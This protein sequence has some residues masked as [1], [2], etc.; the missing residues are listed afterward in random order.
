MSVH[1][2][3]NGQWYV[4]F[5]KRTYR[6][7]KT[8]HEADLFECQLK[9]GEAKANGRGM[10]FEEGFRDYM[11]KQKINTTYGTVQKRYNIYERIIKPHFRVSSRIENITRLDCRHF[12]DWLYSTEYATSYKN[13]ILN[14]LNAIFKHCER[15]FDVGNN[16]ASSLEKFKPRYEEI[17]LK[18]KKQFNVWTP[19]EF[20]RF[21]SCVY[22][23]QYRLFLIVLYFTGMRKGEAM[24]L[25]WS[26]YNSGI[27]DIN[28]NITTKTSKVGYEIKETK[29]VSS[30]RRVS[31][32]S[33]LE[34]LLDTYKQKEMQIAGFNDDWFI[35]GRLKPISTTNLDRVKNKAIYES[36]VKRITIHDL[37]HSHASN[38]FAQKIDYITISK[39][40]GHNSPQTTLNIYAHLIGNTNDIV[41]T[42]LDTSFQS[43]SSTLAR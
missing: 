6:G 43:L 11:E 27:L 32:G 3:K 35:F 5:K 14:Q 26:D 1:K 33:N 15:F 37:R 4:K 9:T 41:N 20:G 22:N 8:Q 7:F 40:L 29:N 19:E 34:F 30:N 31:T 25:K 23:E 16:P 36:G 24:A 12:Y 28:K 42:Y 17:V 39:R 2:R 38:L 13:L 18:R 21:I 10:T